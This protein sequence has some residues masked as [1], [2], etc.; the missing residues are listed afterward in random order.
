MFSAD[1]RPGTAADDDSPAVTTAV[2]PFPQ[3]SGFGKTPAICAEVRRL[4]MGMGACK[5]LRVDHTGEAQI[6]S[7]AGSARG[8]LRAVHAGGGAAD[9]L[10]RRFYFRSGIPGVRHTE[11]FP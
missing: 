11:S 10:R 5:D 6:G 7:E 2:G 3:A 8:L 1:G 9:D 4:G